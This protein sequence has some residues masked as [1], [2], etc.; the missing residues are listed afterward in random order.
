MHVNKLRSAQRPALSVSSC[1]SKM[2]L[3]LDHIATVLDRI[4]ILASG[5]IQSAFLRNRTRTL[6]TVPFRW[7]VHF[8]NV[9]SVSWL[10]YFKSL[11]SV[12][13]RADVRIHVLYSTINGMYCTVLTIIVQCT[14][15]CIGAHEVNP[16]YVH[17]WMHDMTW[18]LSLIVEA[19][20]LSWT[21]PSFKLECLRGNDLKPHLSWQEIWLAPRRT[22]ATCAP[23]HTKKLSRKPRFGIER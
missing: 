1:R 17:A 14:R 13:Y 3:I 5:Q 15:A 21:V 16:M 18:I 22:T 4:G 8:P 10:G 7:S 2:R 9:L 23:Y 12:S 11:I 19:R 6:G 20:E